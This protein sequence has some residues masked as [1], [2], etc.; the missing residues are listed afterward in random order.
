MANPVQVEVVIDP[1]TNEV[2]YEIKGMVGT[3]CT[4]LMEALTKGQQVLHQ[5]QTC[6]YFGS[7]ERPDY[8]NPS[9]E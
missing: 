1:K 2:T 4:D 3:G 9:G 6:E 5:E 8:V 7:N